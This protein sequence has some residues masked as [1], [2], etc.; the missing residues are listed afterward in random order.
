MGRDPPQLDFGVDSQSAGGVTA[1]LMASSNG[2]AEVVQTLLR[3]RAKVDLADQNGRTPL[4]G[5]SFCGHVPICKTL[6]EAGASPNARNCKAVTRS[7]RRRC[8]AMN[9]SRRCCRP[10][11][12]PRSPSPQARAWRCTD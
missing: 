10:L 4:H 2:H 12:R 9:R 6:L 11:G 3:A 5:A 8:G 1:L 7:T